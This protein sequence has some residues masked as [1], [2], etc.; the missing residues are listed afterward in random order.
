MKKREIE[1]REDVCAA[2]L[3]DLTIISGPHAYTGDMAN[4]YVSNETDDVYIGELCDPRLVALVRNAPKI[5]E[6]LQFLRDTDPAVFDPDEDTEWE[7]FVEDLG[8]DL[9]I[10]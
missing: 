4:I 3:H 7:N 10:F 8:Q 9:G 1:T 5:A 2:D 6:L